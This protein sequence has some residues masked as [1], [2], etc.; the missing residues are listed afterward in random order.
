[1][2]CFN[3]IFQCALIHFFM[4]SYFIKFNDLKSVAYNTLFT[5]AFSKPRT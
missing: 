5:A 2:F 3:M 1:M 4:Q